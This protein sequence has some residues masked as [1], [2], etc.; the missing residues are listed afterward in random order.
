M[1]S[2][3]IAY[4]ILKKEKKASSLNK[5][6]IERTSFST[7]PQHQYKDVQENRGKFS[8]EKHGFW[9]FGYAHKS[10][11]VKLDLPK[12]TTQIYPFDPQ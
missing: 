8:M 4:R 11:L 1:D 7:I 2:C 5:L 9:N 3:T 10:Q 6:D 12:T